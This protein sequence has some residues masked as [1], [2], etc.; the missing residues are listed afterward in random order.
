MRD[1]GRRL[2]TGR[3][4]GIFESSQ[5]SKRE[6]AWW[7]SR[8]SSGLSLE[9]TNIER[10]WI[11]QA[12]CRDSCDHNPDALIPC[13]DQVCR[14]TLQSSSVTL[15]WCLMWC[16]C[17]SDV[18]NNRSAAYEKFT[19]KRIPGENDVSSLLYIEQVLVTS[20]LASR[21]LRHDDV[22]S[23]VFTE[24][25]T[26][27]GM[28]ATRS[29]RRQLTHISDHQHDDQ[30]SDQYNETGNDG[31]RPVVIQRARNHVFL[32]THENTFL[33]IKHLKQ[34]VMGSN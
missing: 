10:V 15:V 22:S 4:R 19:E 29:D 13:S 34:S 5:S 30:S 11:C 18:D 24:Q 33:I 1:T 20:V 17:F 8:S 7:E 27:T 25:V 21:I 2:L 23:L 26:V 14:G 6:R 9:W 3:V 12:V 16:Y 31:R 28:L 32:Y